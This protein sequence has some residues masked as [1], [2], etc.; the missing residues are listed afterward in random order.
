MKALSYIVAA[1]SFISAALILVL[2]AR[3]TQMYEDLQISLP[4]FARAVIGSGGWLPA[5][6]LGSIGILLIVTA[7]VGSRRTAL[8]AAIIGLVAT[9]AVVVVTV[10]VLF[11]PLRQAI[12]ELATWGGGV[13]ENPADNRSSEP[14]PGGMF[15][16]APLRSA[17]TLTASPTVAMLFR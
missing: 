15:R 4:V 16:A 14:S 1:I 3:F 12:N 8:V 6:I 7:L 13:R 10:S 17:C 2:V 9:V 5:G 11:L